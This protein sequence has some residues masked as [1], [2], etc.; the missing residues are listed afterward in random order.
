MHPYELSAQEGRRQ[1]RQ[2]SIEFKTEVVASCQQRGVSVAA[3]ARAHDLHP[4]LLRKWIQEHERF[5]DPESAPMPAVRRDVAAQFI[6]LQR[7]QSEAVQ[8]TAVVREDIAIEFEHNGLKATI[9]WPMAQSEQCAT[10]LRAV[11]R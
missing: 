8:I 10:W 11:M 1:R 4:N 3:V 5:G 9:R 6:P 7:A 2:F